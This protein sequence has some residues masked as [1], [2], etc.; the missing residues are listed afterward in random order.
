MNLSSN[1]VLNRLTHF[2]KENHNWISVR[3]I[4]VELYQKTFQ[5]EESKT[6]LYWYKSHEFEQKGYESL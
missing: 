4:V 2:L 5:S 1:Q 3:K 6:Q